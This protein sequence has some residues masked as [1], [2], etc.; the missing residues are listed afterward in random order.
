MEKVIKI[1]CQNYPLHLDGILVK[2]SG[3]RRGHAPDRYTWGISSKLVVACRGNFDRVNLSVESW[4]LF[5]IVYVDHYYIKFRCC[6][7]LNGDHF[8]KQQILLVFCHT[9]FHT[10]ILTLIIT[11]SLFHF[12]ILLKNS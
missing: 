8:L 5:A 1:V 2:R 3:E 12:L 7:Y 11:I 10:Y 4:W 6:S 9:I